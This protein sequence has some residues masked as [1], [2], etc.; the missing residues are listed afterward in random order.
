MFLAPGSGFTEDNFSMHCRWWGW[1]QDDSRTLLLSRTIFLLFL[2]QLDLGSS[3]IRSWRRGTPEIEDFQN[4]RRVDDFPTSMWWTGT[5][6]FFHFYFMLE[7]S[8]FQSC[9]S[10]RCTESDL[11]TRISVVFQRLSSY[12]LLQSA[13]RHSLCWAVGPGWLPAV[14]LRFQF[15]LM[16]I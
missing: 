16:L 13:E 7:F 12:R 5:G 6:C 10:F 15:S 14:I 8:W 4:L 1:C 3:G 9:V 2:H 11:G